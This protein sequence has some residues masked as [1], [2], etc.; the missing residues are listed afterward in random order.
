MAQKGPQETQPAHQDLGRHGRVK[1]KVLA[2]R[3]HTHQERHESAQASD[4]KTNHLHP[5]AAAVRGVG[6][7]E[8]LEEEGEAC[9]KNTSTSARKRLLRR[10]L[11]LP[12]GFYAVGAA[13]ERAALGEV[14][15]PLLHDCSTNIAPQTGSQPTRA[16]PRPRIGA[17]RKDRPPWRSRWTPTPL[18]TP[19]AIRVGR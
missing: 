9:A 18:A 15:A 2:A 13:P 17:D 12:G 6:F 14:G 10:G 5:E 16:R 7:T 1:A 19:A 3:T 4:T 11:L 8:T